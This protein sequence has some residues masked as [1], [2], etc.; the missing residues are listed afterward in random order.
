MNFE[1]D[2][3][4]LSND[5]KD[6]ITM[7]NAGLDLYESRNKTVNEMKLFAKHWDAL[8]KSLKKQT[9]DDVSLKTHTYRNVSLVRM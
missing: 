9:N 5:A 4:K 1:P 6:V 3:Y 2:F 7:V 8:D